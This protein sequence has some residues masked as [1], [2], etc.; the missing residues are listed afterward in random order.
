MN[1]SVSSIRSYFENNKNLKDKNTDGMMMNNFT[2]ST[3][4]KNLLLKTGNGISTS[5]TADTIV[6]RES[7]SDTNFGSSLRR[8][9]TCTCSDS[10][11]NHATSQKNS[12]AQ[13]TGGNSVT[14]RKPGYDGQQNGD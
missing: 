8:A 1:T 6:T 5:N 13:Q 3:N 7:S 4:N 9:A 12:R 2:I 11:D 10:D 14:S